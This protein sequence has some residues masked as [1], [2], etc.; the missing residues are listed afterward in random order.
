MKK[1]LFAI[2]L[3]SALGAAGAAVPA[4]HRDNAIASDVQHGHQLPLADSAT[5][6]SS[7]PAIEFEPAG[8]HEAASIATAAMNGA[9]A[10]H[11]VTRDFPAAN[12]KQAAPR[13]TP[14]SDTP[15]SPVPEPSG[16]AM[17]LSGLLLLFLAP[18]VRAEAGFALGRKKL[19]SRQL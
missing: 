10:H 11:T 9:T 16:V 6:L 15:V 12:S 2:I 4:K 13:S 5:A 17:M 18:G 3:G 8:Q 19:K 14:L 7:E 1:I